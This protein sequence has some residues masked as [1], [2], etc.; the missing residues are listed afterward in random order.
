MRKKILGFVL[1]LSFLSAPFLIFAET[2]NYDASALA[3]KAAIF[4]SPK[5]GSFEEGSTFDVQV[6]LDTKGRSVNT[7]ELHVAFNPRILS[8]VSPSNGKSIVGVWLSP[9]TYSNTNGTIVLIGSI[10]N[11]IVT[12]NGL[13][14][15][16]TFKS[17]VS[18]DAKI[19]ITP[20]SRVLA[21]DGNGTQVETS[22]NG[23]LYSIL[24]KAPEGVRVSSDTHP[25]TDKW[26]NNKNPV[27][28]WEKDSAI[29]DFSYTLDTIPTTI[30]D[31]TADG[32]DLTT[33]YQDLPDGLHYFHIKARRKGIWG[34]TT[35]FP[36]RIDTTPPA[37]FS[38]KN[39]YLKTD[40]LLTF[41]T[42]DS[43]SGTDH[44]EIGLLNEKTAG[45]SPLF[46]NVES[47]Y[48][49]PLENNGEV[50]AI[51]RAYDLAGNVQ[52][53][54]LDLKLLSTPVLFL[55]KYKVPA[56]AGALA[57]VLLILFIII[58]RRTTRRFRRA[59]VI[60]KQEEEYFLANRQML[61]PPPGY[62]Q[63]QPQRY[64]PQPMPQRKMQ[65]TVIHDQPYTPQ[66][67]LGGNEMLN[68]QA[69]QPQG[70]V[71]SQYQYQSDP[72]NYPP[73]Q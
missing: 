31:N 37:V 5:S 4:I 59:W 8:I 62:E 69:E 1:L 64:P 34:N 35:H 52:E 49:V 28:S 39:E 15:T 33:S 56:L 3:Q 53:S 19:T 22:F 9:P 57:L 23:A 67:M 66:K 42:T 10:P 17:N 7:I 20:Q 11:G 13:I 60:A 32:S 21:N 12:S 54:S 30:P 27:L 68:Y 65:P 41:F 58:L 2:I 70:L 51:I 26:Y 73:R 50:R 36:L 40:A 45:G 18:G 44:Y 46:I 55:D 38:I 14:T 25:D 48:Q 71:R 61:A 24:P 6:F 29:S 16:L 43:L 47:P 72:N 63:Q